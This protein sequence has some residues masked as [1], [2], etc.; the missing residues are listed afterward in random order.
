MIFDIVGWIGAGLVIVAY[1]LVSTKK[2][3]PTSIIYQ[4]MNLFG[5]IGVGINVFIK[6]SYPSLL[7]QLMWVLIALYGLYKAKRD[8]I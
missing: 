1:F 8:I 7:I 6:E 2:L 3:L 5:A 4:L